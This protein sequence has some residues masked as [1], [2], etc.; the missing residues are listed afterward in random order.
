[1]DSCGIGGIAISH[2]DNDLV[3]ICGANGLFHGN[4]GREGFPGVGQV[5]GGDLESFGRDE[6]EDIVMFAHDFD[7]GLIACAYFIDGSLTGQVKAMAIEGGRSRV[8]QYGLIGDVDGEHGP[9]DEGRLSRTQ[10]KRDVKS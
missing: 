10:G 2:Q 8:V 3:W 4:N 5:V 1:V 6:E 9:E 7:V